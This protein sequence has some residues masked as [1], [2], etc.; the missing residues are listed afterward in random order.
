V[1]SL[2]LKTGHIEIELGKGL[3]VKS[4]Q[5]VLKC[6]QKKEKTTW[7]SYTDNFPMNRSG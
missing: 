3:K 4:G 6:R 2:K 1:D 7:N 5:D